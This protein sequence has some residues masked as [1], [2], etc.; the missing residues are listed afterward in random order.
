MTQSDLSAWREVA[1]IKNLPAVAAALAN[2][3]APPIALELLS[4]EEFEQVAG[5]PARRMVRPTIVAALLAIA[6]W[7]GATLSV[8]IMV[9]VLVGVLLLAH[10]R[11]VS[12]GYDAACTLVHR[13]VNRVRGTQESI[14]MAYQR[15]CDAASYDPAR[16][17][18]FDVAANGVMALNAPGTPG[19]PPAWMMQDCIPEVYRQA[20]VAILEAW[21]TIHARNES[22]TGA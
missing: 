20:A 4:L 17:D 3:P 19:R 16:P 13:R 10:Y 2:P 8:R 6:P 15:I 9:D 14:H 11:A 1:G 21:N 22:R 7:F 5:R 12:S 18:S